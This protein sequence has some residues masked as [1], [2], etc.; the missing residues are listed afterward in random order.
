M[1]SIISRLARLE[2]QEAHA[3]RAQRIVI[4]YGFLKE[5]PAGCSGPRHVVTV[6]QIPPDELSPTA[7][8]DNWFEWEER[9]GPGPVEDAEGHRHEQIIQ[10]CYVEAKACNSDLS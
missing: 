4:Q 6:R 9:P 7:R 2:R 8:A 5:L 1:R 10:V 3:S